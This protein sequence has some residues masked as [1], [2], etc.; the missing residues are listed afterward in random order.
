MPPPAKGRCST[1]DICAA[2][3]SQF[4]KDCLPCGA[5]SR[6]TSSSA[7]SRAARRHQRG[8]PALSTASRK[9]AESA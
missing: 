6:A 2:L 7:S 4:E 5:D 9:S 8:C 1:G 3:R